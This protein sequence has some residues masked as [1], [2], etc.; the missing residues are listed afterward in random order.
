MRKK[1]FKLIW[2]IST[3]IIQVGNSLM[4]EQIMIIPC[5]CWSLLIFFCFF[6]YMQYFTLLH[7]YVYLLVI[8]FLLEIAPCIADCCTQ[9][10]KVIYTILA[11][12]SLVEAFDDNHCCN[13]LK[14]LQ[15]GEQA[16]VQE[17]SFK[18]HSRLVS[19]LCC[20]L[21]SGRIFK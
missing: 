1:L 19:L 6:T 20:I 18:T 17:Y 8:I 3:L 12:S 10:F 2:E 21:N 14:K 4:H 7:V 9:F 11:F 5:N 13:T 15:R 16:V